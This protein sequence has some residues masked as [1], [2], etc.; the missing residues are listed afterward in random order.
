L[1]EELRLLARSKR[2]K[3]LTE[4][5]QPPRKEVRNVLKAKKMRMRQMSEMEMG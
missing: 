2:V 5:C 1:D 4:P 3:L